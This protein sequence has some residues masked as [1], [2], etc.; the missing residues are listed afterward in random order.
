MQS[1]ITNAKIDEDKRDLYCMLKNTEH[2]YWNKTLLHFFLGMD[3]NYEI[4]YLSCMVTQITL[5]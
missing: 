2:L 5:H 4:R 3:E 1:K